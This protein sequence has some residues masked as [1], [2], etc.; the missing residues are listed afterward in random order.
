MP[1]RAFFFALKRIDKFKGE[2]EPI[3]TSLID[4]HE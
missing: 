1:E 2:G 4:S 3:S